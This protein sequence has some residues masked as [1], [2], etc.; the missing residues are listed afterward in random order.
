MQVK[1]IHS[2]TTTKRVISYKEK[3]KAS[4]PRNKTNTY[5]RGYKRKANRAKLVFGLSQEYDKNTKPGTK[6][7]NVSVF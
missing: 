6:A 2:V 1:Q 3:L 5:Y 7:G 4:D